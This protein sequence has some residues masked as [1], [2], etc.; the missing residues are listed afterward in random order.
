MA[1]QPQQRSLAILA[2][3]FGGGLLIAFLA[4]TLLGGDDESDRDISI[5]PNPTTTSTRATIPPTTITLPVTTLAPIPPPAPTPTSPAVTPGTIV[6]VPTTGGGPPTTSPTTPTTTPTTTAPPSVS[7]ELGALL[8]GVLLGSAEPP[9]DPPSRVDVTYNEDDVVRVTWALD[10]TLTEEEQRYAAREEAFALLRAIQGFDRLGDEQVV[11]RATL[12]DPDTGDP[13]RVVRLV[14]E[15]DT[16]DALD[17][18]T[19]DVLTIF[20]VADIAEI[21]PA[22][23]PTPPPTTSTT[24]TTSP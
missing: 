22:L 11:L 8:E 4:V 24:S 16:L 10:D 21:D 13:S 15:R 7:E 12:P 20:D 19:L 23:E 14:F 6:Q 9:P 3:V 2:G 5:G 17:F 1:L 18:D